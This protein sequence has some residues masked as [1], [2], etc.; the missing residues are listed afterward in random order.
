MVVVVV[1]VVVVSMVVV[2][3]MVV[4]VS[5]VVGCRNVHRRGVPGGVRHV[6]CTMQK[7]SVI[8]VGLIGMRHVG[9]NS[10]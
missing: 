7:A 5:T 10:F 9:S 1:M 3:V 2:V 8:P 4:V 6:R